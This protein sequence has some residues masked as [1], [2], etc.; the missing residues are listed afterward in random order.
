MVDFYL[1]RHGETDM[2]KQARWQGSGIDSELNEDGRRQARELAEKL[3]YAGLDVV[4]SS[5]LKRAHETAVFVG[6]AANVKVV[7]VPELIEAC[8]GDTEGKTH[9]EIRKLFPVLNRQWHCLDD[10][11]LDVRYP[12]GESKREIQQRMTAALK[13]LARTGYQKI[14]I[15]GHS[16]VLRYFFLQTGIRMP[17]VPHGTP[18]LVRYE[19]GVFTYDESNPVYVRPLEKRDVETAV[20]LIKEVFMRFEAPDYP[21]EGVEAFLRFIAPENLEKNVSLYGAF[22]GKELLG[23]AGVRNETHICLLFVKEA[24]Q[25]Q[26]IGKKLIKSVLSTLARDAYKRSTVNAAPTAAGFYERMGFKAVSDV[27]NKDG[28]SFVEMCCSLT[29]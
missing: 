24:F 4:Y 25:K 29:G 26:G 10:E 11:F 23:A 13:K 5:P 6:R 15:S 22:S 16:A 1:F 2:N 3:K 9:L 28:I 17:N 19:N 27:Q 7:D 8:L 18:F 12:N 14:G 21:P 20:A